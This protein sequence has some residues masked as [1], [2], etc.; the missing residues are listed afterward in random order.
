MPP[1]RCRGAGSGYR[2]NR[3]PLALY[4]GT[5][6]PVSVRVCLQCPGQVSP[7][8]RCCC[9]A[10]RTS[11]ILKG[12]FGL[13]CRQNC[14]NSAPQLCLRREQ[15]TNGFIFHCRNRGLYFAFNFV[16]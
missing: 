8:S 15:L 5:T 16:P 10:G 12:P 9:R 14:W 11:A 1:E 7:G 3:D 13:P 6:G 2:H 4:T